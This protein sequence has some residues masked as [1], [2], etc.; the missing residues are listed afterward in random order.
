MPASF[1]SCRVGVEV[2]IVVWSTK[3]PKHK[4]IG[5]LVGW[6]ENLVKAYTLVKYTKYG[7]HVFNDA[8]LCS[9]LQS[10]TPIKCHFNHQR[11]FFYNE[12]F[13]RICSGKFS[14]VTVKAFAKSA[15]HKLQC[16]GIQVL[17]IQI[18]IYFILLWV[19]LHY[20]Q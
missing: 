3:H 16:L 7:A 20:F 8:K 19:V 18:I 17:K 15:C 2:S 10:S 11:R 14:L 9:I 13:T 1:V 5:S 4:A 6:R 12:H